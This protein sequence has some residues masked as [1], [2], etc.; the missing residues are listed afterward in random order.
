MGIEHQLRGM[1]GS[2]YYQGPEDVDLSKADNLKN[3]LEI[4]EVDGS[5]LDRVHEILKGVRIDKV[6]SSGWNCQSWALD[7]LA[8]FKKEGF[9]YDY[10][11]EDGL[12]HWL[13][14]V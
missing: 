14:E 8:D 12:K 11:T 13:K 5:R 7:G 2:F 3:E 10:L 1:P 9:V 6:E 4:G